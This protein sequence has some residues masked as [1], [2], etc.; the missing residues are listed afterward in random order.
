MRV[1]R[2]EERGAL[3]IVVALTVSFVLIPVAALALD[4]GTYYV[5]KE[6]LQQL[7]D[8]AATAG[9]SEL[10]VL[11]RDDS[12][13]DVVTAASVIQNVRAR[14][15]DALCAAA[16]GSGGGWPDA[17]TGSRTWAEDGDEA[18][19]EVSFYQGTPIADQTFLPSQKAG[20]AAGAELITGIRVVTPPSRVTFGLVGSFA[21]GKA[22]ARR[23]ATAAP[24][25]VLPA[26]GFLPMFLRPGESGRFCTSSAPAPPRNT[27]VPLP[28]A[29]VARGYLT[30]PR[31][32]P[33]ENSRAT[34]WNTATGFDRDH[35]PLPG[36]TA[37]VRRYSPT[38]P[39]DLRDLA[40]GL[41]DGI[42]GTHGRLKRG[43]CPNDYD[44]GSVGR[45]SGLESAYLAPFADQRKGDKFALRTLVTGGGK[46]APNQ[47]GWLDPSILRCGRLAVVPVLD[48]L[49]ALLPSTAPDIRYPVR[50][51]R[52][53]W[54]DDR[55][56]EGESAGSFGSLCLERGLYWRPDNWR[57]CSGSLAAYTGY[58][59]DPRLLPATVEGANATNVL[60]EFIGSGLPVT[61]RLLRDV[62]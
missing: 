11:Q 39:A 22:G 24:F 35:L 46:P 15:V 51:L 13:S 36:R 52:L 32:N 34:T 54:L 1:T 14:T 48:G 33:A 50:G 30:A 7:A 23:T 10:A 29:C 8:D 49:P 47:Y 53:V 61:V 19:G 27:R 42:S 21:D 4:L 62:R 41:I 56:W 59:L 20:S 45:A 2:H 43:T 3:A 44:A 25:T 16:T 38:S 37:T 28:R 40:P 12:G 26:A 9:A 57:G 5:R 17:C 18:N 58:I 60:P 6:A 31:T 55:M